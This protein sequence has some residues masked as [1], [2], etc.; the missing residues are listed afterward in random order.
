[1][2]SAVMIR[3]RSSQ[4]LCCGWGSL[5]LGFTCSLTIGLKNEIWLWVSLQ[6]SRS[7]CTIYIAKSVPNRQHPSTLGMLDHENL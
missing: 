4:Y 5:S 3:Y 1:M 6:P 7:G 2:N